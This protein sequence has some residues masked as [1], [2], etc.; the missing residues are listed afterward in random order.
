VRES[1]RSTWLEGELTW[2]GMASI[3]GRFG[4]GSFDAM[5]INLFLN[6]HFSAIIT[7]DKEIAY[8]IKA[9]K[10]PGKFVIVPSKLDL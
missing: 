3:V 6:S 1:D 10:P 4:I 9:L 8:V 5:I 2:E 7:A